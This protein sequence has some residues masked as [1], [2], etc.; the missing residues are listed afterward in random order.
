[1]GQQ[2]RHKSWNASTGDPSANGS[3]EHYKMGNEDIKPDTITYNTATTA[4]ANSL[5]KSWNASRG[6]PSANGRAIQDGERG[7]K[8][9]YDNLQLCYLCMGEYPRLKRWN[10]S[11]GAS[12]TNG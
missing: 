10:A 9:Q 6:D 8:A 12:K 7:R 11:R 4:R 1:M 5:H 2:S 3:K